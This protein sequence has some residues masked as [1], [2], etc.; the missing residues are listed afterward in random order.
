MNTTPHPLTMLLRSRP[1]NLVLG[2]VLA[3]AWGLFCYAHLQAFQRSGDWSYL[4]F[5]ASESLVAV[6]FLVRSEPVR[7]SHSALDW[8]LAIAATFVPFLFSPT[9]EAVL[10]AARLVIVA[11]ILLQI[12]G[13]LSLNRSFGLVAAHR[14]LKT[15]GLYGVV[16]HPLYASYLLSYTGYILNNTSVLNVTVSALAG[17]LMMAR[18]LREER[19]LARDPG[20]RAYMAQVKYRVIPRLF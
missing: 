2:T 10:P 8:G 7:V 12:G 3:W 9:S 14:T 20:Y 1:L 16:R 13:L 18:L 15:N 4:L 5:C 19:F 11:G 17:A 6:L